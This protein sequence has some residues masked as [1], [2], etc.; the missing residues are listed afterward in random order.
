MALPGMIPGPA[1]A[2]A[3]VLPILAPVVDFHDNPD[4]GSSTR[5]WATRSA[6]GPF[7]FLC[8]TSAF[9][10]GGF[11]SATFGG[12]ACNLVAAVP[13]GSG[14]YK[15]AIFSIRGPQS[16]DVVITATGTQ[17]TPYLSVLSTSNVQDIAG[18]GTSQEDTGSEPGVMT[19]ASPGPGGLRL[20]VFTSTFQ[21]SP[22]T[23]TNATEL[24]DTNQGSDRHAVAYSLGDDGS[25]VTADQNGGDIGM[26]GE[27][28]R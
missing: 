15:A 28:F 13:T 18:R 23:W 26:I 25:Q 3:Q 21:L 14:A 17:Q 6:A 2:A 12:N 4:S 19:V 7:V 11:T 10:S 8:V 24:V 9:S 20:F 16:G 5:T 27:G 22:V 1:F